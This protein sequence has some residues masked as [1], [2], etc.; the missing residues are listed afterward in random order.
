MADLSI[1]AGD[2]ADRIETLSGNTT[3]G[4]ALDHLNRGY[5]RALGGIDPRDPEG[6]AHTW[7]FLRPSD[8][9]IFWTTATG[10]AS[11][12]PSKDN[13]TTT[14]TSAA[15]MFHPE[16]VGHNVVFTATENSYA[17]AS[18]TSTTVVVVT[19]D[20]SGE[21][22]A[23]TMTVTPDGVMPLPDDFGGI[24][25]NFVYA[26]SSSTSVGDLEE[27]SI[28]RMD[29]LRRDD[30]AQALTRYWTIKPRSIVATGQKYDLV[31]HPV[32][33]ADRTVNYAYEVRVILL[34]DATAVYPVGMPLFHRAVE[35]AG[36]AEAEV[37]LGHVPGVHGPR[38]AEAM[39]AAIDSDGGGYGSD[40]V[41]VDMWEVS[42]KTSRSW[43][44]TDRNRMWS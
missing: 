39:A 10:A 19:G 1:T 21:A 18:Y 4:N 23:D 5:T 34:T 44:D 24:I 43:R 11:G 41:S 2:M 14:V 15:A 8:T 27:V 3:A 26:Y 9:I 31:I 33:D 28:E 25:T 20:A 7:S 32:P 29:R 17:I 13:G 16:M 35:E 42:G 30:N 22:D 37:S 6:E 36:L 12:A 40:D 38:Y